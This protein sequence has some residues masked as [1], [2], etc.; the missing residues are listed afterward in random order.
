MDCHASRLLLKGDT[1]R[2]DS[3]MIARVARSYELQFQAGRK[4]SKLPQWAKFLVQLGSSVAQAQVADRKVV[5]AISVPTSSYAAAFVALGRLLS[6]Q[7]QEP[8]KSALDAHF[9]HLASLKHGTQLV[10]F[11][12]EALYRGS[13]LG[14][15]RC[16]DEDCILINIKGGKCFVPK[17]RC[18]L[19]ELQ[20]ESEDG[21][22]PVTSKG[23]LRNPKPFV[24]QFFSLAEHY[25]VLCTTSK[26]VL[27]VGE[28]NRLRTE[29]QSPFQIPNG[30]KPYEGTLQ[31]LVRVAK[32]SAGGVGCRADVLARSRGHAGPASLAAASKAFVV[33]DG[34]VSVIKWVHQFPASDS[35]C[36]LCRT[37]AEF[38]TAM[39]L[40]NTRYLEQAR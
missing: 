8:E 21:S 17:P 6:E 26:S 35:V 20:P 1:E 37:E 36:I 32:F 22:P 28:K 18:L 38:G 19:V 11:N 39:D 25:R 5:V 29:L 3:E 40:A 13:F 24:S 16:H 2:A 34:A 33:L 15:V 30:S 4:W 27:I 31:D 23:R 7:I 9:Q 10:Y 12:G 14:I